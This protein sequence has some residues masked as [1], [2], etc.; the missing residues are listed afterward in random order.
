[1]IRTQT[2]KLWTRLYRKRNVLLLRL[3][4]P[5]NADGTAL[6]TSPTCRCL[7]SFVGLVSQFD[8]NS[9]SYRSWRAHDFALFQP[10]VT[11]TI[12]STPLRPQARLWAYHRPAAVLSASLTTGKIQQTPNS[13]VTKPF[14]SPTW[15]SLTTATSI[16]S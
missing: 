16:V 11:I 8:S 3:P 5:T 4:Q 15:K 14:G 2:S 1:M 7:V 12:N 9:L 6:R 13:Q 10:L